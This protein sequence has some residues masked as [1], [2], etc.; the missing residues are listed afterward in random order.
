MPDLVATI[1]QEIDARLQ[2]LRPLAREASDLQR[3]LAALDGLSAATASDGRAQ[4]RP[5]GQRASSSRSR[6]ARGDV[7]S[8]I[9]EYGSR[10]TESVGTLSRFVAFCQRCVKQSSTG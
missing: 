9:I 5:S 6:S 1:R 7:G 8:R 4:R 2:E 10:L 3:A